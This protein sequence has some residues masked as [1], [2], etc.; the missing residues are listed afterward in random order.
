MQLHSG[1]LKLKGFPSF[2]TRFGKY[3]LL[4]LHDLEVTERFFAKYGNKT[5]FIARFVPVI[6]HLISIPAGAGR[7][8]LFPFCVYTIVGGCMWNS[9]LAYCGLRL[10]EH[11]EVVRSYSEVVDIFVLVLMAAALGWFVRAH[12][13]QY[14][15]AKSAASRTK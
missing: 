13:K 15:S 11:W 14:R 10:K 3:L 9:F 8:H 7:M 1:V 2:V 6:R 4:N 5:I 12:I